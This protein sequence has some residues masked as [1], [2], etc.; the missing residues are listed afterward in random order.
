M[1]IWYTSDTH[2]WHANVIKYCKRPFETVEEMN[3]E[4]IR[5]WNERVAP[6]DTVF[7]LGDFAMG[8]RSVI[9]PTRA[10][11]NGKIHLVKGNHDRS[12]TAMLAEGFDVVTTEAGLFDYV[13]GMHIAVFMH[14]HPVT[15]FATRYPLSMPGEWDMYIHLCG[16]VHEEFA[17]QG[18]VINV[19]VDVSDF[20]PLTLA[21]LLTR[22]AN[23]G[24]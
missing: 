5:R 8:P 10:K 17:R 11:L 14:H 13:D 6:G 3:R 16:H 9:A 7:H 21:E 2:F 22:D 1:T 18:N 12:V 24:P 23:I 4:L 15:D 20:R 19:G